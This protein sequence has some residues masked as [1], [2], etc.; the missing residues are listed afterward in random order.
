MSKLPSTPGLYNLPIQVSLLAFLHS[1]LP[2][3]P[4]IR[5]DS[6]LPGRPGQVSVGEKKLAGPIGVVNES[7]TVT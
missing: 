5:K 2:A 1:V 3:D 6:H 4:S 7:S